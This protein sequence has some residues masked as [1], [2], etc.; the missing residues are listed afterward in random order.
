MD[1][2]LVLDKIRPGAAWRMSDTYF[3]LVATWEDA[4]QTCPTEAEIEAVWEEIQAGPT[5]V[6]SKYAKLQQID[7]WTATAI[8]SGFA[9]ATTGIVATY[10]STEADQQNIMLMLQAAQTAS[11]ATH[12]LYKGQIPIR[13]VLEGQNCK[14]VLQHNAAQMQQ[15]VID[16]ALHIG[17]CKQTG[18]KLQGE[19]AAAK[20]VEEIDAIKWP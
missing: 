18:W 16:M 11:F 12:P 4:Q 5:L 2:A 10:D 1:I 7:T 8:T 14:Q 6:E 3:N 13:A 15:L 19:V 9:S 20:T 17:T